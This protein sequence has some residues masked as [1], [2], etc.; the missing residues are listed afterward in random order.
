MIFDGRRL[1]E[2]PDSEIEAFV[3]GAH[4]ERAEVEFKAK[5]NIRNDDDRIEILS[6]I[7]SFANAHGGHIFVGVNDDGNGRAAGWSAQSEEDLRRCEDSLRQS[8]HEYIRERIPDLELT[9]RSIRN[10]ALLLIRIPESDRK[11]HMVSYHH[12]TRFCMRYDDGKREMTREEIRDAFINRESERISA[13]LAE[14]IVVP[15]FGPTFDER[16]SRASAD[17]PFQERDPQVL[18]EAVLRRSERMASPPEMFFA[19]IPA[20]PHSIESDPDLR[21][22]AKGMRESGWNLRRVLREIRQT[23]Y[24]FECGS[25]NS[26]LVLR[27]LENGVVTA[28][29]PINDAITRPPLGVWRPNGAAL[30]PYAVVEYPLSFCILIQNLHQIL[31]EQNCGGEIVMIYRGIRG[32][33]LRPYRPGIVGYDMDFEVRAFPD[34]CFE[35][36]VE[37]DASFE[38]N[39][40]A[41]KLIHRFYRAFGHESKVIPFW[42]S[43]TRRF[44]SLATP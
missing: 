22:L 29:V 2:V 34:D 31:P 18:R 23:K 27:I 3:Q 14:R 7:V 37:V 35:Y 13:V 4:G 15:T 8:A 43:T 25:E 24:G 32:Y 44:D 28:T 33:C 26:S 10:N 30:Y 40:V 6:D 9:V 11:P 42:D 12:L 5:Y 17:E 1:H 38:P 21:I 19:Y 20:S 39:E 16:V 41:Y 36:W